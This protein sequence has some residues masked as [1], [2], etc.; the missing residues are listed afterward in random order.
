VQ[1]DVAA[2]SKRAAGAIG[3]AAGQRLH[4]QIVADEQASEADLAADDPLDDRARGGRRLVGIDRRVDHM[5][6][7]AHRHVAEQPE[8][9]E[10]GAA[11]LFKRGVHARQ[12][13][14]AVDGGAAMARHVLDHRQDAAGEKAFAGGAAEFR[15][16]LR[17]VAEGAVADDGVVLAGQTQV[18]DRRAVD[19]DA[20]LG[21]LAS[22]ELGIEPHRLD[23]LGAAT[24]R[25][26]A[27]TAGGRHG[28]PGRRLQP[29]DTAALL[30]DQHRR[31]GAA[32][33]VAQIVDQGPDLIRCLAVALEQDE[34]ERVG[35][36]EEHPLRVAQRRPGAAEN[37]GNYRH[38]PVPNVTAPPPCRPGP[39]A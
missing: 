29:G 30:V 25:Q 11:Q 37:G 21:E 2:G 27:E 7:D 28:A 19:R 4:G 6:A 10:V 38:R 33:S 23:S 36:A 20:E 8:R 15:H 22:E 17:V 12:R 32:D 1:G 3:E 14:V 13:M 18:E 35:F 26:L 5:R 9:P 16:Q 24:A 39:S 34:A 31:V